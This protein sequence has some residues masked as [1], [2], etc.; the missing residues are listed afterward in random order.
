MKQLILGILIL[1]NIIVIIHFVY[2]I[3]YMGNMNDENMFYLV[4]SG[5]GLLTLGILSL[6][7]KVFLHP[8]S[9][10]DTMKI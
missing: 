3:F 4:I 10:S 2:D 5:I 1:I 6:A 8:A 9:F 7:L